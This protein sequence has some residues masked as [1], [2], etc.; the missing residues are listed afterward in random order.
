VLA[1]SADDATLAGVA[2]VAGCV[3]ALCVVSLLAAC[4]NGRNTTQAT[5]TLLSS[6]TRAYPIGTCPPAAMKGVYWSFRLHDRDGNAT[7][8]DCGTIRGTVLQTH[9]EPDG[10]LH[11]KVQLDPLYQHYLAPGNEYQT[12][13]SHCTPRPG[14]PQQCVQNLMVLE[15]I[16]QHCHGIYPY[17]QN[18]A[19]RGDFLD[20]APPVAG[21]YIEA[22]GY[23][24]RDFDI[25]HRLEGYP[26]AADG[27]AEL[28]PVS[29]MR[30]ITPAPA[31]TANPTETSER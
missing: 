26:K 10:D 12:V 19:D 2:R 25:L 5:T 18:C 16:P 7:Q 17:S 27:W 6:A 21:D 13:P 29:G 4:G 31:N 8:D 3:L 23:A 1:R 20:P 15:I 24:V 9:E 28:H 11:I 22:T 14:A 30:V